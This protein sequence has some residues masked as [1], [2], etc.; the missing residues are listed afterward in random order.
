MNFPDPFVAAFWPMLEQAVPRLSLIVRHTAFDEDFP[1]YGAT[2]GNSDVEVRCG[3]D[4]GR[5][6]MSLRRVDGEH[7]F[8]LSILLATLIGETCDPLDVQSLVSRFVEHYSDIVESID[9]EPFN[10]RY[11]ER[12]AARLGGHGPW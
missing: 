11:L 5:P 10:T 12:Y 2:F 4:R 7:W 3:V 1:Y 8:Q 9:S 6:A